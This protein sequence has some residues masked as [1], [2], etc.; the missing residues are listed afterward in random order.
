MTGLLL[1][2]TIGPALLVL[3][4]WWLPPRCHL[5]WTL[6][7][8]GTLGLLAVAT[9][10]GIWLFPPWWLP[11]A[12]ATLVL[13]VALWRWPRSA[14]LPWW[15]A[16]AT[17][18]VALGLS[19]LLAGG[20]ALLGSRLL[21]GLQG[22][23]VAPVSLAWPLQGSRFL[24]VNG[25]N[26]LMVNA[27][28]ESLL[29]DDPRFIPWRGNRWAVDVVATDAMGLRADGLMPTEPSRYRVFGMPVLAPCG[30]RVIVAVD[31]LPDMPVP[32]FDR[33]NLAGNHVMLDCEGVH[34]ALAHFRQ[35]SVRVKVGDTVRVGQPLAEVGNSGGTQEP[36]L[37]LHAQRPGPPG[38]PMG[39]KPLP[40]R[41]D[42]RFLVRGDRIDARTLTP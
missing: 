28:L 18:W 15:P 41:L 10:A 13:L 31:G 27:H 35:G 7:L 8:L 1:A 22:P 4:L 12:A 16:G 40:M 23:A 42:D 30:G 14:P 2:Q 33:A 34:I 36:H 3:W 29:S 19:A 26:N 9:R 11:H 17:G 39:G 37:H 24:V 5:G 21:A 25:G 38:A 20:S 32:Q 6:Q